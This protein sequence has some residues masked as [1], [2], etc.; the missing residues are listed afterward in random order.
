MKIM[1]FDSIC[2]LC[3]ANTNFVIRN[4]KTKRIYATSTQSEL[5]Q[6]LCRQ[7][8]IDP[9][10]PTT[11]VFID[12]NNVF[13][14]SDAALRIAKYLKSPFSAFQILTIIP[15]KTRDKI[16]DIVA[17][18]RYKIFGKRKTCSIP[19]KNIRNRFI[20]KQSDLTETQE[21]KTIFETII[22]NNYEKLPALLRRLHDGRKTETWKGMITVERSSNM[23]GH[24]IGTVIGL[25]ERMQRQP[26]EMTFH[27]ER[28][29]KSAWTR[30]FHN[31]TMKSI[32]EVKEDGQ[33]NLM[34]DT[35]WPV[36]IGLKTTASSNKIEYTGKKAYIFG[37]AL[38]A[39]LN[40][41][42]TS[43]EECH[44]DHIT[45]N[46]SINIPVIGRISRYHGVLYPPG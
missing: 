37:L 2:P 14:K 30:T 40:P 27:A 15:K 32:T 36:S 44:D 17:T 41:K 39:I 3:S 5:G 19:D 24:T 33:D 34:L 12:D 9:T 46:V 10:N 35:M 16:Y 8:N 25:P 26:F 18:N 22:G 28:N 31:K 21:Q 23:L 29:A 38:P 43:S 6:I 42:I 4:D 45:F 7:N 1:I 11:F 13:I 20:E